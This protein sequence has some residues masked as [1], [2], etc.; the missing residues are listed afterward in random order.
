MEQIIS[1]D[2]TPIAYRRS[3]SGPPLV[4]VHGT[5]GSG[6]RWTPVLPALEAHFSLYAV[7]RRGRGQ[8][9]DAGSYAIEREFE[10]VAAV[11]DSIGR[12]VHLLGHS[13]GGICALEAALLTPNI[14]KLI[15]YEPPI[16]VE[17]VQIYPPGAIE[18]LQALL[19]A[20]DRAGLLAAFSGEIVKMP[21]QEFQ[22]L[23]DSP[24]WPA[25][26]AAAHTLPRELRAHEG[27]RFQAERFKSLATPTLLLLGG[28]SPYFFK[29]AIEAI[30]AALPNRRVV[31]LP[32]QQHIAMD[33]APELFAKE[34]VGFLAEEE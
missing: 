25:R 26:L 9:G 18:R 8:S 19:D 34:V 7:D 6:V 1:K 10:D 28:D 24:A 23:K 15:L 11:V 14:R 2:K 29:A 30:A 13:Y 20:G 27:Y 31:S 32:G 22:L 4:L 21:P 12:P 33:T 16:P 3:G 5:G 17:G